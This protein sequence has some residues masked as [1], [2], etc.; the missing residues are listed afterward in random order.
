MG[1]RVLH[2]CSFAQRGASA[3]GFDLVSA[4]V[5]D[6]FILTDRQAS[7]LA[8]LGCGALRTL[9]TYLTGAC[10]KLGVFAWDH[11]HGLATRTGDMPV[12]EVEGEVVLRKAGP[13]WRPGAGNDVY[14]LLGPLRNAWAGHVPQVDIQLQQPWRLLQ[15]LDQQLHRGMLWLVRWSAYDLVSDMTIQVQHEVFLKAVE[16]FGAA[17]T[18]V[19]HVRILN[20]DAPSRGYLLLDALAP[21]A[22]VRVWFGVLRDNLSDRVHDVLQ[23]RHILHKAL[24]LL[25]PLGPALDLC[26]HQ[27]QRLL[28]GLRLPPV[29]VQRGL[30]A[31]VAHQDQAPF[32]QNRRNTRAQLPRREVHRLAQ[33]MP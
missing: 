15:R 4:L 13:A 1:D 7:P 27:A 11:R 24:M 21:R 30:E 16:R 22:T 28:S 32:L 6:L 17:L 29:E 14:A 31:A 33:R 23:G 8:A 20:G 26:Q 19:P 5:L 18:A 3:L 2:S 9:W 25:Q 10:W 12:G